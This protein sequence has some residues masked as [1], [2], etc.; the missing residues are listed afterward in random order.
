[1]SRAVSQA[2]VCGIPGACEPEFALGYRTPS[3]RPYPYRVFE[4][5][6][7]PAATGVALKSIGGV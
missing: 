2:L 6:A 5:P 4:W 7:S 1:M 3:A